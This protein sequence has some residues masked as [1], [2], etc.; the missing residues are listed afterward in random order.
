MYVS[1]IYLYNA[2]LSDD[3]NKFDVSEHWCLIIDLGDGY[4]S[5]KIEWVQQIFH[6]GTLEHWLQMVD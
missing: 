4:L 5:L 3:G 1:H 6:F 2:N